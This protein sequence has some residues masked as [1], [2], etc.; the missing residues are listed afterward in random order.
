M[1]DS[2]DWDRESTESHAP[3]MEKKDAGETK[4]DETKNK[5]KREDE[6]GD[7]VAGGEGRE[8]KRQAMTPQDQVP[9]VKTDDKNSELEKRAREFWERAPERVKEAA[10]KA[11]DFGE[12]KRYR[13][14]NFIHLFSGPQ[15]NL[16]AALIEGSKRAGIEVRCRSVDIKMDG[17]HNLRDAEKWKE[18]GTEVDN[19]DYDG[20]HGGF[21][22][23]SFSRVRWRKAPGYPEPVR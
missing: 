23:G 12:F 7:I 20:S 19:G 8:E 2:A 14:F 4:D 13:T 9:K 6:D 15:D 10:K 21:P 11:R 17:A 1:E 22:C 5:R 3:V 16:A 18:L